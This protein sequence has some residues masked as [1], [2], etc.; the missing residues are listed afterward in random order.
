MLAPESH[1][2][3]CNS[4]FSDNRV[5]VGHLAAPKARKETT[6]KQEAV[7]FHIKAQKALHGKVEQQT[8][9]P[10]LYFDRALPETTSFDWY[11]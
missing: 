3:S 6:A 1:F 7:F 5:T 8:V 2:Y 9:K 11:N 4:L 10:L